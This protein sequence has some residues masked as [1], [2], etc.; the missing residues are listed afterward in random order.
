MPTTRIATLGRERTLATLARK[1]FQIDTGRGSADILRRA[2]AALLRAN[3]RLSDPDGFRPGGTIVVPVLPGVDLSADVTVAAANG[4]GLG[5]ETG[6]RLQAAA[7]RIEDAFTQA[8]RARQELLAR[9][10]DRRFLTEA[11]Q[12]LPEAGD[13]LRRTADRL[14]REEAQA[15]ETSQRLQ[16]GVAAAAEALDRLEGMARRMVRD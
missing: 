6:L 15:E 8:A 14:R 13:L 2:E 5:S 7:G 1:V 16:A 11:A 12:N 4:D 3:P 9:V 10:G